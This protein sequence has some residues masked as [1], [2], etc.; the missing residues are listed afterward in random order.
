MARV[1]SRS[2]SPV[3][4]PSLTSIPPRSKVAFAD[5]VNFSSDARVSSPRRKKPMSMS[6]S[7]TPSP[8]CPSSSGHTSGSSSNSRATS[9]NSDHHEVHR[10]EAK[11]SGSRLRSK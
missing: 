7:P 5:F 10:G 11:A 2:C 4:S 9:L 1:Q 3:Q 8:H 6:G